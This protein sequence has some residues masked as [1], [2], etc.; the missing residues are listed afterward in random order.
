MNSAKWTWFAIGYQCGFAY[1]IAFMVN[2]F[3]SLFTGHAN[4]IGVILAVAL[5]ACMVYML[6]FKKYSEAVK[7]T[8]PVKV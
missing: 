1:A 2:Q 4:V 8:S 6:F 5:L 3:G 7:L